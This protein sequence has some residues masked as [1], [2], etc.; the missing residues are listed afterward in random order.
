[1]IMIS[2]QTK[3]RL[4]AFYIYRELLS[5]K[6]YKRVSNYL[7]PIGVGLS[8]NL[9]EYGVPF[10]SF[11][12]YLVPLIVQSL[13][14]G[15]SAFSNRYNLKLGDLPRLRDDPFFLMDGTGNIVCTEVGTNRLIKDMN[16]KHIDDLQTGDGK[17][18]D[19]IT[20]GRDEIFEI[21]IP[22]KSSW[23]EVFTTQATPY[24][25]SVWLH[26]ITRLKLKDEGL[27][28]VLKFNSSINNAHFEHHD[29]Q[30]ILSS[31]AQELIG[32]GY[33]GAFIIRDTGNGEYKGYCYREELDGAL[34]RSDEFALQHDDHLPVFASRKNNNF[35]RANIDEFSDPQEFYKNYS[36]HP[37][38]KEFLAAPIVNLID[39]HS[40]QVSI[41][42]FNKERNITKDDELLLE[43][44][45]ASAQSLINMADKS[46]ENE[47]LFYASISG[48]CAA[49]EYSDDITGQHVWRVNTYAELLADKMCL[50]ADVVSAIGKVAA[51]H[52]IG[53]VAI[54]EL[55]K[56]T[57][58]YTPEQR[59]EMQ[60]HT[61]IGADIIAKMQDKLT[62]ENTALQMAKEIALNHHQYWDGTGYPGLKRENG[63]IIAHDFCAACHDYESLQPLKGG[64]IPI[65]ALIVGLADSYDALRNARQYK[66]SFSHEKTI[67]IMT[68]DDRTGIAGIDRW[69]PDVWPMFIENQCKFDE[70]YQDMS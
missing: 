42:A 2:K 52:D 60:S 31:L 38:I 49:G 48:L 61:I 40:E 35:V 67:Q 54:P 43:P 19:K 39:F 30:T 33:Q 34:I 63:E 14:R 69:G 16:I 17:L 51:L 36:F 13:T 65:H 41:I 15:I 24:S 45:V 25:Y 57:A 23:F 58:K 64:E 68:K 10:H 4:I 6:K 47:S 66:P 28:R 44:L 53:K 29:V 11:A 20:N 59:K 1:M 7:V 8:L 56:F 21:Y 27:K 37:K 32:L 18:L 12:P 26:D 62:S 5:V 70:I 22:E 55:I 46:L 3:V 50:S 9:I